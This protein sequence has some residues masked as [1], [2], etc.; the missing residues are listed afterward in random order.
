MKGF[1][2]ALLACCFFFIVLFAIS[3]YIRFSAERL[4]PSER[5]KTSVFNDTAISF[6][7]TGSI[8]IDASTESDLA[9]I[10]GFAHAKTHNWQLFV[11]QQIAAGK[12]SA[13]FGAN[14][15]QTDALIKALEVETKAKSIFSFLSEENQALLKAYSSGI[16]TYYARNQR[17][18]DIR[19][20]KHDL[21]P[22]K[23]EAYTPI[24]LWLLELVVDNPAINQDALI[25]A[26]GLELDLNQK[27]LLFSA[28]PNTK[29]VDLS[30]HSSNKNLL[31]QILLFHSYWV[32]LSIKLGLKSMD[33]GNF[34]IAH[35]DVD[36]SSGIISTRSEP[37]NGFKK[38]LVSEINLKEQHL[39]VLNQVGSP[40]FWMKSNKKTFEKYSIDRSGDGLHSLN[41]LAVDADTREKIQPK[42]IHLN[43][44][45]KDLKLFEF[46][47]F[48]KNHFIFSDKKD[49]DKP[50]ST[51]LVLAENATLKDLSTTYNTLLEMSF[52]NKYTHDVGISFYEIMGIDEDQL[53]NYTKKNENILEQDNGLLNLTSSNTNA[54][55]SNKMEGFMISN[56]AM[57]VKN[58]QSYFNGWQND[59]F[60]IEYLQT[61]LLVDKKQTTDK[62]SK[63]LTN[64]YS[65]FAAKTLIDI[66]PLLISNSNTNEDI[67]VA[68]AYFDNW[69]YLFDENAAAATIFEYFYQKLI[70]NIFS[71]EISPELFEMLK[72]QSTLLPVLTL[73]TLNNSFSFFDNK[74]TTTKETKDE[75]ILESLN[76]AMLSVRREFGNQTEDWRWENY[77]ARKTP[78]KNDSQTTSIT[79]YHDLM[80]LPVNNTSPVFSKGH[81]STP[82][83]VIMVKNYQTQNMQVLRNATL[84]MLN[85][86]ES[87]FRGISTEYPFM[88]KQN[89]WLNIAK[90]NNK[91]T[92]IRITLTPE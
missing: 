36:N 10:I 37:D 42:A 61:E 83:R 20:A 74:Q 45:D 43:F 55:S 14:W 16:N 21:I 39:A 88:S 13:Y 19:F 24:S 51:A 70:E 27:E 63:L 92:A 58:E 91:A 90:L 33:V 79:T 75:V 87:I 89:D 72:Q 66:E 76:Q 81:W 1:V 77:L 26:L 67:K 53:I 44:D 82:N 3:S 73:F 40:I 7:S 4:N 8:S 31:D 47:F 29:V 56:G 69:N 2:K 12:V 71:D 50:T 5:I 59:P 35:T 41:L 49:W 85:D 30:A 80:L 84:L 48:D 62:L 32:D 60:T 28:L 18:L 54:I 38:Y 22:T 78:N 17:S 25:V 52:T 64:S 9:F 86:T 57:I 34:S 6:D 11:N 15:Y 46:H 68:S 23:W 65:S